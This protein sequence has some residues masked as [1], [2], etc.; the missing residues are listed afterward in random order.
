MVVILDDS[1]WQLGDEIWISTSP[2]RPL[3]FNRSTGR[4]YGPSDLIVIKP[5]KKPIPAA[6]AVQRMAKPCQLSPDEN[7]FVDRF[8][9]SSKPSTRPIGARR[10]RARACKAFP[11][12]Y[13]N[14]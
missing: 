1:G 8:I 3:L 13:E 10:Y 14:K 4:K 9:K 7:R 12:I 11:R 5:G 2:E 6:V